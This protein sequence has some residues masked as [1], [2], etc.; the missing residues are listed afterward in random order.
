[1]KCAVYTRVSTSM[2][3]E[4]EYNSC[5]AQR[6]RIMSY[7][8]SQ[9]DLEFF[10]EYSD[11]GYS[12]GDLERPALKEI[13]RDI[14]DK[15]IDVVLTYKIDRLTRSSKDFYALIEFFE[16]H[17][18]S[19]VSVTE[20]FDTSSPSGRLLRNIML[21]FAQFER[22]MT[23]ERIK[24][25]L[26]QK[27]MKGLYN[28]SLTPLGYKRVDKK[29][30]ID[31]KMAKN[32]NE[33]YEIFVTTGSFKKVMEFV[34]QKGIKHPKKNK[35]LSEHGAYCILRHPVYIGK[36]TWRGKLY[37]AVHEPIISEELFYEVQGLTK[38]RP[39]KKA[40]HKNYY[41]SRLIK[42]GECGSSMT[43]TFTNKQK[44]RY[45]YY[46]CAKVVKEGKAACS[47]KE[48]N[49]EKLEEFIVENLDRIS[50]DRN[51]IESLAFEMLHNFPQSRG[52]E[53]WDRF[54]KNLTD[55]VMHVLHRFGS[56]YKKGSTLEKALVVKRTIEKI[57]FKKE[58][59]EVLISL[60]DKTTPKLTEGLDNRLALAASGG[61]GGGVNLHAHACS[62]SSELKNT[63]RLGF[64]P[65]V[66]FYQDNHLAGGCFQPLSHLS[67][68][69]K[70]VGTF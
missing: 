25:K 16:K 64:E 22:E 17:N 4:V 36:I 34:R 42:C 6:D 29:L 46:K 43:N 30:A 47:L 48:V 19:Y 65:R 44:R 18:V 9:E 40:L 27:A 66:P 56:D 49:A 33:I 68:F 58:T 20:R 8:K 39:K 24:D 14:Q 41:L 32:I 3:A 12:G 35:P 31:K 21:T 55:K 61:R 10:K 5:E 60:E 28:G 15:K 62:S 38:E 53:P 50:K 54:E 13:L 51:Y 1:M 11:P 57:H 69:F 45:Y 37:P 26:E 59:M 52:F 70:S 7:I 23:S 2:Q 67:K 63:E